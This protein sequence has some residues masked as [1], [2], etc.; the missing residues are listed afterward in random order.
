MRRVVKT[1]A[2]L[3]ASAG[4]GAA[5][6]SF[7]KT[8]EGLRTVA[9]RDVGGKPTICYGHTAGVSMGQEHTPEECEYMLNHDLARYVRYVDM[10]AHRHLPDEVRI[11]LTSFV[12]NLGESRYSNSTVLKLIR[13][14]QLHAACAQMER[15]KYVCPHGVCR[16]VPGVKERRLAE[17]ELCRIGADKVEDA[18]R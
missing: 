13:Q 17:A 3:L 9:Y 2:A 5:A 10:T 14:G 4:F 1:A 11:S 15:W 6:L 8:E 12:Y 7:V 18:S 16:E